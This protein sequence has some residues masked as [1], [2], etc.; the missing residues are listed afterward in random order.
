M[1]AKA[2]ADAF[3]LHIGGQE[4]KPG[5]QIF[6]IQPGDGVDHV[7]NIQDLTRF[8]DD[9]CDQI[10]ASHV[11][12]H[13]PQASVLGTLRELHRILKPGGEL[14]ISVPDLDTLCRQFLDPELDLGAKFHIMRMMFG[15]Q[16][17]AH[18]FHYIGF[19]LQMLTECLSDVGFASVERVDDFGL[20]QDFSSFAPYG[21]PISLNVVAYK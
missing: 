6:N 16:V 18:D 14:M 3:R 8:A 10:Y 11:L 2:D 12:E 17:D 4:A 1:K 9:C 13:V 19:S 20:F 21:L 7:G 5:W 15:A